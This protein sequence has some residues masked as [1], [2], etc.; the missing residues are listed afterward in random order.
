[1]SPL[2]DS[3]EEE[4]VGPPRVGVKP[5]LLTKAEIDFLRGQLANPTP[6]YAKVMKHRII[7]KIKVFV[8]LELPL[9]KEAAKRWPDLLDAL[10]PMV[11]TGSNPVTTYSNHLTRNGC[12]RGGPGGI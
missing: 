4:T 7:S 11:T 2:N 12:S 5:A 9:L 8:N 10:K 6:N 1:V 3:P